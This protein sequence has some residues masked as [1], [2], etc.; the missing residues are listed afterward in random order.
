MTR[1]LPLARPSRA[2]ALR[3][4]FVASQPTQVPG[5]AAEKEENPRARRWN[6]P[7]I[8]ETR[9]HF[10]ASLSEF[11]Q[12][13]YSLYSFWLEFSQHGPHRDACGKNADADQLTRCQVKCAVD[14]HPGVIAAKRFHNRAGDSV[15]K[16]ISREDLAV[17]F[18]PAVQPREADVEE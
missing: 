13:L 17:E 2:S 1:S 12:P 6:G 15:A 16:Q 5:F 3:I 7:L 10:M 11:W 4:P 8:L 14:V 18:F 9:E